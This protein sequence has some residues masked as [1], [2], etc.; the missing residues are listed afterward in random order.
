MATQVEGSGA[1][2][3]SDELIEWLKKNKLQNEQLIKFLT[4]EEIE[5]VDD[6][7]IF[8]NSL[9]DDKRFTEILVSKG[10]KIGKISKL[11]KALNNYAPEQKNDEIQKESSGSILML[12]T[13]EKEAIQLLSATLFDIESKLKLLP[14]YSNKLSLSK[15][16]VKKNINDICKEW[17]QLIHNHKQ[18]LF[19]WFE[20]IEQSEL[21]KNKL[22]NKQLNDQLHSLQETKSKCQNLMS[23]ASIN[24]IWTP[25]KA[26]NTNKT[27]KQENILSL[28]NNCVNNLDKSLKIPKTNVF[29]QIEFTPFC[30]EK[31]Q[32]LLT[33][34]ISLQAKTMLVV[35]VNNDNNAIKFSIRVRTGKKIDLCSSRELFVK[36]IGN[37]SISDDEKKDE[38]T[39]VT[40][41]L[42]QNNECSVSF[43][44]LIDTLGIQQQYAAYIVEHFGKI[45]V[46]RDDVSFTFEFDAIQK[47]P[48]A[49]SV[50][51]T[52]HAKITE[53]GTRIQALGKGCPYV[54]VSS[55]IGWDKGIHQWKVTSNGSGPG[56]NVVGVVTDYSAASKHDQEMGSWGKC[57]YYSG[58]NSSICKTGG[59]K[60]VNV[61]KWSTGDKI[62]IT[63]DCIEWKVTFHKN[64]KLVGTYE[65]ED[66]NEKYYPCIQMCGCKGHDYKVS[67]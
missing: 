39:A 11:L 44:E 31:S 30:K 37:V 24:D 21:E 25:K 45:I 32:E 50:T 60:V 67:F 34:N 17:I 58:C 59:K 64:N 28:V 42:I 4:E 48:F 46:K 33:R 8:K 52:N 6:L 15:E 29:D 10:V 55:S 20:S 57:L 13:K 56:Y 9:G 12:D 23:F 26:T 62:T 49:F 53:N 36:V 27:E 66:K 40:K 7:T 65:L 41:L 43:K 22:L 14:E 54:R 19:K 51:D 1:V 47:T 3:V 61:E 16:A 38:K 2:T 35:D 5:S 63:L 18:S